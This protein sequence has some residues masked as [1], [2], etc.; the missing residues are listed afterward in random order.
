MLQDVVN[1]LGRRLDF[2]VSGGK[3]QGTTNAIGFDGVWHSKTATLVVECKT[4]DAFPVNL[5][6][7]AGYR[8]K[9][10][11]EHAIPPASGVLLV[12]ART[13]T[14]SLEAQVRGSK[15]AW[16][17]RIIGLEALIK[18]VSVKEG[19]MSEEV[20]TRIHSLLLPIEYTCVDRIV[21]IVFTTTEDKAQALVID[22]NPDSGKGAN[23]VDQL[24]LKLAIAA[25]YGKVRDLTLIRRKFSLFS[26]PGDQTH[27]VVVLSKRYETDR[28]YWYGYLKIQRE[29]LAAAKSSVMV[30]GMIDRPTSV[31]ALP[32]AKLEEIIPKTNYRQYGKREYWDIYFRDHDGKLWLW[33]PPVGKEEDLS[34]FVV[35]L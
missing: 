1:E 15:H 21:D 25:S 17:M 29:W 31:I 5:E 20:V 2:V 27:A 7:L 11:N 10:I 12:V 8:E 9:L 33:L 14:G 28:A 23:E 6:K 30:F 32:F 24:S 3:Y 22:S 19:S 4:T 16:A 34:E 13:D 18:L 26:D 35:H